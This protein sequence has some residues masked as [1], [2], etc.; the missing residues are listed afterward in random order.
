[1]VFD[2]DLHDFCIKDDKG[3]KIFYDALIVQ[4]LSMHKGEE[5]VYLYIDVDP[6]TIKILRCYSG[7]SKDGRLLGTKY[8]NIND[9]E[10]E[11]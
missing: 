5:E 4:V 9:N 1:M 10:I 8:F 11:K 2:V 3:N 6:L 7:N